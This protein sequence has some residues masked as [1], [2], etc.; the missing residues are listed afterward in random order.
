MYNCPTVYISKFLDIILS[1]LVQELP[2]FIKDIPKFLQIIND[3]LIPANS[4]HKPLLFI[5]DVSSLHTSIPHYGALETSK[6]SLNK[7]N[8]KSISTSTLLQL[9][10]PVLKINTFHFNGRYFS[11]KQGVVM[12][13]K[14]GPSVACLFMGYL[15]EFFWGLSM[16]TPHQSYINNILMTC[17]SCFMF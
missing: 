8:N 9:I 15:E 10:E 17:W 1:L 12:G 4:N 13:T 11:Q 2:S 14:I 7:H 6:H 16:N 5:M 3:F